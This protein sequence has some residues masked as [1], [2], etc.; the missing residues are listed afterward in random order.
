MSDLISVVFAFLRLLLV[1]FL[2]PFFLLFPA[3]Q[4]NESYWQAVGRRIVSTLQWTF[5]V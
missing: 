5:L 4:S 3:R 2:I 1:L